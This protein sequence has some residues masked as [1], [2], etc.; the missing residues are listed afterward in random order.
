M[1]YRFALISNMQ[2]L[3]D[4]HLIVTTLYQKGKQKAKH[5][6]GII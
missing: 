5:H 1:F 2:T 3:S 4:I 6:I